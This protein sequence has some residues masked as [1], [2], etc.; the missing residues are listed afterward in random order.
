M[1]RDAA[2]ADQVQFLGGIPIRGRIE[3]ESCWDAAGVADAIVHTAAMVTQQRS[4][5]TY[6]AVNVTGTRFAAQAAV[7]SGARLVHL[8]SVSVYGRRSAISRGA[9]DED[10][11]WAPLA[12]TDYYARS[13]RLAEQ[14]LWSVTRANGVSALAL[15][16]C[17]IYGERDRV[18][19]P[20]VIRALRFK[21]SPIIGHGNNVLAAVYAGN[22]AAA[23]VAA[24]GHPDVEGPFNITNDGPM[25]QREFFAAVAEAMGQR[26]KL[27]R[28]PLVAA[29]ALAVS[30]FRLQRLIRPGRYPGM[31]A[32]A[33]SF[34][35]TE[36]PYTSERAERQ[37]GWRPTTAPIE[38]VARAVRS[39]MNQK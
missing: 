28:I 19:L 5:E 39:F 16:P 29:K 17:V 23:I 14:V 11:P 25:T 12:S 36:N 31:P 33:A 35:A 4:W 26:V 32:S 1:V 18:F 30:Y 20:H 2:G 37:L 27:V 34:L 3:D 8:S 22:V 38:A 6:R 24:L 15:R 21:M 9:V 13:K 10:A 7:R